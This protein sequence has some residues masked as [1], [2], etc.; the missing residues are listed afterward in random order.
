MNGWEY[1]KPEA[2]LVDY[3]PETGLL[4]ASN[5]DW[6]EEDLGHA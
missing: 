5:E 1:R 4:S 3:L 6:G 2:V